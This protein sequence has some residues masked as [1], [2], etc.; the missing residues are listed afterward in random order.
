MSVLNSSLWSK[1]LYISLRTADFCTGLKSELEKALPAL[2]RSA[3]Y[4][5]ES[6]INVMPSKIRVAIET[7]KNLLSL[8]LESVDVNAK[9]RGGNET[10]KNWF[11]N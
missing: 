11:Q 3:T 2:G 4:L 8:I 7:A 10:P 9:I 6:R 1:T 5:K